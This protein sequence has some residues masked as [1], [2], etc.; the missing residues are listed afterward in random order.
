MTITS[1]IPSAKAPNM[2][3]VIPK[4]RRATRS[5]RLQHAGSCGFDRRDITI[6]DGHEV[7]FMALTGV[8]APLEPFGL[9]TDSPFRSAQAFRLR[10][11]YPT[12]T[13]RG[14]RSRMPGQGLLS[15]VASCGPPRDSER[16]P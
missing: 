7:A 3:Q 5:T 4:T 2:I 6:G 11:H 14:S 13:L 9:N 8:G 12:A 15:R 16:F 10:L 1:V